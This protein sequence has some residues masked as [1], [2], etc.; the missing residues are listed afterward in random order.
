MDNNN[1]KKDMEILH[2]KQLAAENNE[3]FKKLQRLIYLFS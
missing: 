2:L 3:K 1:N